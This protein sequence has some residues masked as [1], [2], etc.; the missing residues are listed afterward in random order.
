MWHKRDNI[1][2]VIEALN[3]GVNVI[4]DR[5]VYS[6]MAH[7]GGKME[8]CS[9]RDNMFT[10]L[11]KLE[12]ELLGLPIPDVR[13]FLHMPY[14][15]SL[16]LK[17]LRSEKLDELERSK[18]HL[19]KAEQTYF[20]LVRRYDFKTFECVCEN[21]IKTIEEINQEL[22]DYVLN[23]LVKEDKNYME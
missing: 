7:Q 14:L 2:K 16:E 4:L 17:A 11:E 1:G 3:S 23:T 15:Q 20:E 8:T 10:W 19:L 12:F 13:I 5:Y 22:Y 18:E 6:N 9:E 21:R